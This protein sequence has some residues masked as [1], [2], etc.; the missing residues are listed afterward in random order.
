MDITLALTA[1]SETVVAGPTLNSAD[2]AVEFARGRGFRVERIL[3]LDRATEASR[4]Y[5]LPRAREGWRVVELDAGDLGLAR[6]ALAE[7]AGGRFVAFLD[8]DDLI[9]E[10][11]LAAAGAALAAAEDEGRQVIAHPELN[12]FFD[13]AQS[14][15]VN[16]PDTD[17]LFAPAYWR[18]ANYFDS[19]AM[20]PRA[21]FREVPY[22]GRDMEAG[23]GYED[24]R[25]NLETTAA[26]WSH[27]TVR[28]TIIF[29]RRRDISLLGEL[30]REGTLLW[31]LDDL[32]IDARPPRHGEGANGH[33]LRRAVPGAA[34]GLGSA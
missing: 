9:S 33:A 6:N 4:A 20:A 26:G 18:H 23:F 3:G 25:W 7:I 8:A 27:A 17:A 29:K 14:C 2:A 22:A 19:L 21:A 10:N 1:H 30:K 15:L 34:R 24:W 12:V 13:A 31:D 32:A 5:F 28:D 11:W 16:R